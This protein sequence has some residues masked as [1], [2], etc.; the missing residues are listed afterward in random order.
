MEYV[1]F[2]PGVSAEE[3][4][5]VTPRALYGVGVCPGVRIDEVDAVVNGACACNPEIQDRGTHP[6]NH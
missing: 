1:V 3:E 5:D 6:S 4:L 2:P